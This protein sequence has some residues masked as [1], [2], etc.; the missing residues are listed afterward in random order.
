[1]VVVGQNVS[2]GVPSQNYSSLT[3]SKIKNGA[4]LLLKFNDFSC[5]IV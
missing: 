3:I 4:L 5:I 2:V 1:M